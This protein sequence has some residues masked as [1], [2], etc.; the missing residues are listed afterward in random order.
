MYCV[1][2]DATA[3]DSFQVS[4]ERI[5][6]LI[7]VIA[8][9]LK[10]V[11]LDAWLGEP[12]NDFDRIYGMARG[13]FALDH[14]EPV[15]PERLALLGGVSPSRMRAMISGD[16]VNLKRD[17]NKMIPITGALNWLEGRETF[18]PRSGGIKPSADQID[19]EQPTAPGLLPV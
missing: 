14:N 8:R 11:D 9:F 17:D 5:H 16:T 7:S 19:D 15:R 3:A 4:Q 6:K 13:R 2:L 18:V 1:D 12:E 10:A